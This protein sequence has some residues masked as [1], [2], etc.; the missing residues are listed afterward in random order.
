MKLQ[1]SLQFIKESDKNEFSLQAPVIRYAKN[2]RIPLIPLSVSPEIL[3]T[4]NSVGFEGLSAA[5]R[6]RNV[7]DPDGFVQTVSIPAFQRYTKEV[8]PIHL[9]I[10]L[11]HTFD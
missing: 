4:V 8:S 9:C 3:K 10:I 7:P 1:Q 6:D 11:N 2:N 5:E